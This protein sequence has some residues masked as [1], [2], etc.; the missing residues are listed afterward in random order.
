MTLWYWIFFAL[1][2]LLVVG[3]MVTVLLENRQ[4]SKAIAWI[5]VLIFLPVVGLILYIFFGQNT[6]K[7][8]RISGKTID[9]LSWNALPSYADQLDAKL[10][11]SHGR[12]MRQFLTQN[13]AI[14]LNTDD[15]AIYT[16][17]YDYYLALFEALGKARHHVYLITFIFDDDPLGRLVADALADCAARGVEVRLIYDD[18]GCWRVPTAFYEQMKSRGIAVEAFMPVRFPALTSRIN[19]RNHRKLCVIDDEVAFI[20]GMNIAMRYVKE[21]RDTHLRVRGDIVE[22]MRLNHQFNRRSRAFHRSW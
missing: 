22:A 4:P 3:T 18:V 2:A 11:D 9:N 8:R 13:N 14:P 5:L 10:L 17:G 1:Y 7:E 16:N 20:G 12:L 6:R 19:Y 15:V 21:W